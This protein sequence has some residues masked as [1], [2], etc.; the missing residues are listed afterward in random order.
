MLLFLSP[1]ISIYV[2]KTIIIYFHTT[3]FTQHLVLNT[4]QSLYQALNSIEVKFGLQERK[5]IKQVKLLSRRKVFSYNS[6]LVFQSFLYIYPYYNLAGSYESVRLLVLLGTISFYYYT[7]SGRQI[8]YYLGYSD[9]S[10]CYFSS[11]F[12]LKIL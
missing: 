9:I 10:L 6:L 3:L 1:R 7:D 12:T 2:T 4:N 8:Q 11:N 5:Q